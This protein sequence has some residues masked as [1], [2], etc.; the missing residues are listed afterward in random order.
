MSF[1]DLDL[2]IEA[3]ETVAMVGPSG[4]GKSTLISLLLRLADPEEGR[5][6]CDGVDLARVDPREWHRRV[7]WVP[8]RP[9]VFAGTVAENL[10]LFHPDADSARV[11]W[12]G[13]RGA[14][15]NWI[16]PNSPDP[17]SGQ[18]R[19]MDTVATLTKV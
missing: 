14:H 5:I 8:Q 17:I 1:E 9:T 4:G 2:V 11:W 10:R 12:D 18:L 6:S 15:P 19:F 7:S 16:I 13:R 3:G